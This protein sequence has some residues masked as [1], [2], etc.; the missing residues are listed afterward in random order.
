MGLS[1]L[2]VLFFAVIGDLEARRDIGT[3][4]NTAERWIASEIPLATR[5][6][7]DIW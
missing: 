7:A 1:L 6:G 4:G 3:T 5:S 2:F